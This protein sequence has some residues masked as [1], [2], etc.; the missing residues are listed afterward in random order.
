VKNALA[1]LTIILLERLPLGNAI[2]AFASFTGVKRRFTES[3]YEDGLVVVD[4]Y[5]HHPTEIR[6]TL[7]GARSKYPTK[8][9]VAI[10]QPHTFTRTTAFLNEFGEA[11]SLADKAYVCD[12]FGSAR[13]S[14]GGASAEDLINKIPTS[15][16][17]DFNTIDK[18]KNYQDAVLIF[19]GA[20]DIEKYQ[21]AYKEK[22][23]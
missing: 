14:S 2:A 16:K 19:M 21:T 15:E 9:I 22:L 7:D 11:L 20:G 3:F 8:Q 12:I 6:A 13:E 18:L 4:D 23:S 5:A 17:L 1:V 10:F